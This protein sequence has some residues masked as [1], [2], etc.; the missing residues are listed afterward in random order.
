MAM[1]VLPER[2]LPSPVRVLRRGVSWRTT[3]R[4]LA[5]A[6]QLGPERP[7]WRLEALL[8]QWVPGLDGVSHR[9]TAA[10]AV[11]ADGLPLIGPLPGVPAAIAG[12]YGDL[13]ELQ[14]LTAVRWAAGAMV[15]GRDATP[16]LFRAARVVA[17]PAVPQ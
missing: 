11:A 6:Q 16:A 3:S 17:P 9:W 13:G 2:R 1:D 12:A 8:A 4:G 5:A 7:F 15:S 14:A 10:R